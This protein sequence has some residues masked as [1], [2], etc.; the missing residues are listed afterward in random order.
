M[1]TEDSLEK[2]KMTRRIDRKLRRQKRR[3]RW[4]D[5]NVNNSGLTIEDLRKNAVGIK[6]YSRPVTQLSM[7]YFGLAQG[8]TL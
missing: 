5:S 3:I 2:A 6:K 1:P 7:F 8:P 4:V